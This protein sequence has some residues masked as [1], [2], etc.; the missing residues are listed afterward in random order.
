MHFHNSE[1]PTISL[2]YWNC[3]PFSLR[4]LITEGLCGFRCVINGDV[5][6]EAPFCAVCIV[7][8][9]FS[10]ESV[11]FCFVWTGGCERPLYSQQCCKDNTWCMEMGP[12]IQAN[13]LQTWDVFQIHLSGFHVP[14][15]WWEKNTSSGLIG[16]NLRFDL[17]YICHSDDLSSRQAYLLYCSLWT[18][19]ERIINMLIIYLAFIRKFNQNHA[20]LLHGHSQ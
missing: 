9:N 10:F 1:P 2:L 12:S 3:S 15:V 7:T 16:R 20:S 11:L 14:D 8:W 4:R 5:S 19:L 13:K 6:R 17:S 18:M